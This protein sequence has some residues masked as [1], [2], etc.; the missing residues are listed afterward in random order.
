MAERKDWAFEDRGTEG[1]LETPGGEV[2]VHSKS[3]A[4]SHLEGAR[5]SYIPNVYTPY[6]SQEGDVEGWN[7]TSR[8]VW[9]S[10][11]PDK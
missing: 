2:V 11:L 5:Q 9:D 6:P 8:R 4:L 3:E 10:S 7:E 1:T